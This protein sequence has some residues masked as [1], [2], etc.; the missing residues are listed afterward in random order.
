MTKDIHPLLALPMK[1]ECITDIQLSNPPGT[2]ILFQYLE[3][4]FAYCRSWEK[5]DDNTPKIWSH[6]VDW[7]VERPAFPE[8]HAFFT[9]WRLSHQ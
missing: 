7:V 6:D 9:A 8:E 2:A 4:N 5:G 3:K 1:L